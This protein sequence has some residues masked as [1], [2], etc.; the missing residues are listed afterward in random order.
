MY[1]TAQALLQKK[2][3]QALMDPVTGSK[4]SVILTDASGEIVGDFICGNAELAGRVN[5]LRDI[6]PEGLHDAKYG[7]MTDESIERELMA[8]QWRAQRDSW[9]A[10]KALVPIDP[11]PTVQMTTVPGLGEALVRFA[12]DKLDWI[13]AIAN[14][15]SSRPQELRQL[16]DRWQEKLST[17]VP[18]SPAKEPD[19]V[20]V[21]PAQEEPEDIAEILPEMAPQSGEPEIPPLPQDG[22]EVVKEI[23]MSEEMTVREV[24]AEAKN[25]RVYA[26]VLYQDRQGV[27]T[28]RN[29]LV[30][31]LTQTYAFVNCDMR[32]TENKRKFVT[33]Y[34][35][36]GG[37]VRLPGRSPRQFDDEKEVIKTAGVLANRKFIIDSIQWAELTDVPVPPKT[38]NATFVCPTDDHAG[39]HGQV[40][41][42][43]NPKSLVDSGHWTV[44]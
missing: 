34:R 19:F 31:G 27:M 28:T 7:Y 36:R 9:E 32:F 13:R 23:S 42:C 12:Q 25:K 6:T 4:V 10:R 18:Q 24:L 40:W 21:T 30:Q 2:G 41:E 8:E 15:G 11:A 35:N 1:E 38:G 44:L 33:D 3:Y 5:R 14:K 39:K 26:R 43:A 16:D 17:M 29:I 37:R 22:E 20:L